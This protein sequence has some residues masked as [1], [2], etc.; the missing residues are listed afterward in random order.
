MGIFEQNSILQISDLLYSFILKYLY[1]MIKE[2]LYM[3]ARMLS[4]YNFN[5]PVDYISSFLENKKSLDEQ[6]SLRQFSNEIGLRSSAPIIDILQRKKKIK[7]KL[8]QSLLQGLDIDK[9]ERMYFEA[10][11]GK[12]QTDSFETKKLFDMMLLQLSPSIKGEYSMYTSDQL[13]LFSHWIYM[14]VLSLSEIC[15]SDFTV[16]FIKHKLREDVPTDQIEKALFDLLSHG[17]LSVD[18]SG[19]IKK[20]YL[21]NT[22]KADVKHKSVHL[23]Y[24]MVCSLAI[25]SIAVPLNQREYN[26]F[27]FAVDEKNIPLAKEIIRKCRNDLSKLSEKDN[28]NQ[29]YQANLM[30]FPLTTLNEDNI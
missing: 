21:R 15:E 25:K 3:E 9:S 17:L 2:T 26:C 13:D 11:I 29:I 8:A 18:S 6:F 7:N 14:A 23:Y 27:S 28:P 19:K 20:T 30:L 10:L 5:D 16:E 12:S 24:K 4:I 22:T 1:S